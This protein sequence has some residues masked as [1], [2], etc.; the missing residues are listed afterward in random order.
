MTRSRRFVIKGGY[1]VTMN[2]SREVFPGGYVATAGQRIE[3]VGPL[4]EWEGRPTEGE[5][6]DARGMIVI[7]GLIN[8]HQHFYYHLF[9]G[10]ANGLLIED[11]F[12][13]LV[14]PVLPHLTDEDMEL[15]SYLAGIEMLRTGTTCCLH[16][17]RTTTTGETL[18]RIAAPTAEL[19]FRQVIGK[20]VQC[21][22][23]GNPRHPRDLDEEIAFVNELI[24]K[25]NGAHDGLV[26]LALVTECNA[27][28][29]DQQVTSE[30][31]LTE[32]KRL[33]TKYG[34]KISSH[35]SG[36]TLSFDKS[37]LQVL[38]KT[39]RTDTQTLMQL[40]LLDSTYIMVHA[41][42][43]T[44]TDIRFMAESGCSAVYTPTS[45]AVRGGGIGP[46][47]AMVQ[48]GVNVALGSDGPMV[49][50][51]VDMVE[52]MKACSFLQNVKHLDPTIMPPERCLEMATINAA[53]ALGLEAEIGSLEPG[54]LADI[55]IFDLRTPHATPAHNPLS[56]LVYSA[57]GTDLHTLFVD[58]RPVVRDGELTT[59]ADTG[60][61]L[62]AA[63]ARGGEIIQKAG[64][65]DRALPKW[66]K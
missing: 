2:S 49:D 7:P 50:Y 58:G 37:Y 36:G 60:R 17:L 14:F 61:V 38:R 31:L 26:R 23:P 65:S 1:V 4:A 18:R 27:I 52:Q 6:I 34:L 32:G 10:L 45:E 66:P 20:E 21:R 57:R 56:S 24:P 16:H 48:A 64:L 12:P 8:A 53:R 19:G 63:T 39:G 30:D 28:F 13:A 40:G 3:A 55:A 15:T 11:W 59:F 29:I 5:V 25:W 62:Q 44:P 46:A 22:L 42:N 47:A 51:S 35:V 9:K 43:V 33:A 41:I 54:K